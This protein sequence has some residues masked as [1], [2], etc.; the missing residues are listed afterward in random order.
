MRLREF[1]SDSDGYDP[2]PDNIIKIIQ[3]DCRPFLDQIGGNL[4]MHAIHRGTH[5]HNHGQNIERGLWKYRTQQMRA[6]KDMPVEAHHVIDNWFFDKFGTR[7][8]SQ[9]TFGTGSMMLASEYGMSHIMLPI[10]EFD[11]CWSPTVEDLFKE[12]GQGL[13]PWVRDASVITKW[14]ST[15]QYQQNNNLVQAIASGNEIMIHCESY[16]MLQLN[17][18]RIFHS[19]ISSL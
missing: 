13:N 1:T 19:Q 10:G 2:T 11:F 3:R 18:A 15:L 6:P 14:L 5:Q 17:F 9:A 8:R 7:Y 12:F 4:A 16:Y